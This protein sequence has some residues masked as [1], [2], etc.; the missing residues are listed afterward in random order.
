MPES[1]LELA[2]EAMKEQSSAG[3]FFPDRARRYAPRPVMWG[4]AMEVPEMVF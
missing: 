2:D 4:V 3:V 1:T